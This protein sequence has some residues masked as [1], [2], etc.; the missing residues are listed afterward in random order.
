MSTIFDISP[1]VTNL[2][3]PILVTGAGGFVGANL[4]R[5]LLK[6]RND[7]FGTVQS[8]PSWRLIDLNP[9][10]V[11]EVDLCDPA[12]VRNLIESIK[13][14]TVFDCAAYGAYSFEMDEARI[15]STNFIAKVGLVSLLMERGVAAYLHAGS[16]SEYGTNCAAPQEDSEMRPNSAYAVSKNA[17]SS[18][19]YY[20][21]KQKSFPCANLRLYS[22]YGPYED[23]SRLMPTLVRKASL[24]EL[25]S[26]VAPE[27]SRDFVYVDDACHAFILCAAKMN[28]DIFGESFNIGSGQKTSMRELAATAKEV[29]KVR[30]EPVFG[31]MESRKWDLANWYSN[32][33][34][35]AKMLGWAASTTLA[36]GLQRMRNWLV[37][38]S[39]EEY[40][41]TS[42]QHRA[43][44]KRSV[45][46]IIAC[47]RDGQAVPIMY[48]RL[49]RTFQ[50]LDID[51]EIIFVNDSSPDNTE[52]VVLE[53]TRKD[54]RVLGI[55]HS[56][57]FGSQMAFR[58]GMELASK[59][60]VV[61]LDGDLQDPPELIAEFYVEWEKGAE[62]IYGRRVK[63]EMSWIWEISYKA[64]Y[65]AFAAL[66]Y[67][68]VPKDAGDF[69]LIDRKAVNWILQCG[70]RDLFMR[71][72]RAYVGFKQVGV[73]YIRPERMFGKSTNNILNNIDWAKRGIFSFS[74]TPLKM[75]TAAGVGIF[76][77]SFL[78]GVIL[79]VLKVLMPESAPR[80]ITMLSMLIIAF[81]SLNLM[82]I[83]I[84]G[85]YVGKVMLEVKARPRL[86]RAGLIRNG[87]ISR[88]ISP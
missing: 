79:A 68:A 60:A 21:G 34:K 66:S 83:G 71:G 56:R 16:S 42:K 63:R 22:V 26:F 62:V 58:S 32:S 50:S 5:M 6:H 69:S 29:F 37:N 73:D 10:G 27:I 14:Q 2:R 61:L 85:E 65:R 17:M 82:A 18:F 35:A 40:A 44:R 45:S 52:E 23:G 20:V 1:F 72:L 38:M 19:L 48:E 57:N 8:M 87:V 25:P 49:T 55:T 36:D 75:V 64:F 31:S 78:V 47:Y 59:D 28:P 80:G 88:K 74:E 41:E 46:A 70:E 30:Q 33:T 81:G 12:A 53:I 9:A 86:I 39:A 15:Q 76:S 3:G 84:V 54:P 51:Y 4:L 7:V 77:V 24:G 43:P 11:L 67:V 13:P